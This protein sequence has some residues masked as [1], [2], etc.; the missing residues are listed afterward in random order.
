MKAH[1]PQDIDCGCM[2]CLKALSNE[3]KDSAALITEPSG[4]G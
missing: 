1:S 2:S 4:K 3:N